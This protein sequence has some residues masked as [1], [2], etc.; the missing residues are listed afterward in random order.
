MGWSISLLT[1]AL[2][3]NGEGIR[4]VLRL[5]GDRVV[6]AGALKNL[7]DVTHRQA[8]RDT[9]VASVVVE[10]IATDHQC[11]QGDVAGVHRLHRDARLG[12]VQVRFSHQ[13]PHGL[14]DLLEE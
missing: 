10:P 1:F 13:L 2:E 6:V 12:A 14:D 8:E 3:H 4:G 7:G 9:A 5:E 11:A